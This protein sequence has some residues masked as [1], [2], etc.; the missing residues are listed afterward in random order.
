MAVVQHMERPLP[1]TA[2][3]SFAHSI[4]IFELTAIDIDWG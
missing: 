2:A 4:Y 3:I 1:L